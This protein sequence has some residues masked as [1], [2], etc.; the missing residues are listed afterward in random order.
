MRRVLEGIA[1]GDITASGA[2]THN[3]GRALARI[4]DLS[5][6]GPT[7]PA[8]LKKAVIRLAAV[9]QTGSPRK[10]WFAAAEWVLVTLKTG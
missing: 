10:D 2:F 3:V 1:I 7:P 5:L 9:L 4:S 6:T 8:T